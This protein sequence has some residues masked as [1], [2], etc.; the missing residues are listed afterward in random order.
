MTE[1]MHFS[2]Y[3]RLFNTSTI[4]LFFQVVWLMQKQQFASQEE[5]LLTDG[6]KENK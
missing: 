4:S 3:F 5:Q 6:K 2:I 1:I